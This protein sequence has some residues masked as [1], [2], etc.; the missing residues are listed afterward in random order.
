MEPCRTVGKRRRNR[1]RRLQ[2]FKWDFDRAN[3]SFCLLA[4]FG[5]DGGNLP[6]GEPDSVVRKRCAIGSALMLEAGAC[7]GAAHA[8]Y[9]E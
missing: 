6:T 7:P 3:G 4:G 2:D 8:L 9:Q 5:G 1:C